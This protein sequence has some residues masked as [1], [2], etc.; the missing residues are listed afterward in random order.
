MGVTIKMTRL[1]YLIYIYLFTYQSLLIS[2]STAL[3]IGITGQDG[4]Y[5]TEF[6]LHKGY[7]VHGISR[8]CSTS[9][10]SNIDHL[11]SNKTLEDRLFVHIA[12]L[13][14]T[15]SI[16][17]IIEKTLPDEIYDL[18]GQ[19]DV[20]ISFDL[21][22]Q[23]ADLSG[24]GVL[25]VL[26]AIRL[27]HNKAKVYNASTSELFGYSPP[28]QSETTPF[29]PRSPYA[30][31][32][33]FAHWIGINYR[34]S[35][36]MYVSNG[37][38]FNHESPRRG[39]N[40]LSRK[41]TKSLALILKKQQNVLFLGN[42]NAKKD[43]GFAPDYVECMWKILQQNEPGDYVIGSGIQH[44]VREFVQEA[45]GYAGIELSW[46]GNDILEVGVIKT[47]IDRW[48]GVLTPG[49]VVVRINPKFFRPAE[50][51][52][53]IANPEKANKELGWKSKIQFSDLVKIMVDADLSGVGLEPIGEGI[54]ILK[55]NFTY[56][57]KP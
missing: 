13:S 35:Y 7:T 30:V 38:L 26:E 34:E 21:P 19:T 44:S 50:V 27:S 57:N 23:T 9:N 1:T 51:F 17:T 53:Q 15:E 54:S 31:A 52:S 29:Y 25:R 18:A 41:I 10:T 47:V 48:K 24:L 32:K 20:R 14:D 12:D 49:A 36:N 55:K 33:L 2:A 6:L 16:R 42:L 37:I 11:L 4:S 43:W 40:F 39:D 28:P 3:I 8:R 46:Q 22:I 56:L 5:L 45:F